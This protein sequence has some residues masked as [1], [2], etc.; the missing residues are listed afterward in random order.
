MRVPISWLK[1]FVDIQISPEELADRLTL[2]GMVGEAVDYVGVE[3]AAGAGWG[4][5][6]SGP[7]PPG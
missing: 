7:A 3:P 1:D 6:L 5:D 2:A 4:T